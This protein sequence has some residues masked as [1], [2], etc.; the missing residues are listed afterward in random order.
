MTAKLVTVQSSTSLSALMSEAYEFYP[1]PEWLSDDLR[2]LTEPAIEQ[3]GRYV[4]LAFG[5]N[6]KTD[7]A[8]DLI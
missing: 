3:A 5:R 6:V 7:A 2:P 4:G 1:G 8:V